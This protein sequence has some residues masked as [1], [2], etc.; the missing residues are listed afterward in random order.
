MDLVS[1]ARQYSMKPDMIFGWRPDDIQGAPI[2]LYFDFEQFEICKNPAT[3]TPYPVYYYGKRYIHSIT[4]HRQFANQS[5]AS[6]PD[7]TLSSYHMRF[8]PQENI[9]DAMCQKSKFAQD[10]RS[11]IGMNP[12]LKVE[13]FLR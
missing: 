13:P 11:F 8:P 5:K 12:D 7:S 10:K 2:P 6:G 1:D 4:M 9:F 3:Q